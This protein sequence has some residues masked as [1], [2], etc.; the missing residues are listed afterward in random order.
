MPLG[1]EPD[2]ESIVH[3]RSRSNRVILDR[4]YLVVQV[5][6]TCKKLAAWRI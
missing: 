6:A 1:R 2:S 4:E 3:R 5:I